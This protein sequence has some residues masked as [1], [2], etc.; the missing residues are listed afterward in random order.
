[1]EPSLRQRKVPRVRKGRVRRMLRA[2]PM[3]LLL[4]AMLQPM[5]QPQQLTALPLQLMLQHRLLMA[6]PPPMEPSL[7]QRKVPRVR[8]GRVR[9]MLRAKPMVLLLVGML[10]PMPQPQQPTALPLQLMLQPQR[11]LMLLSLSQPPPTAPQ[12]LLMALLLQARKL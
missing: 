1:M 9:R 5:P 7:R 12:L 8:K 3:S 10:Q 4:Q 6:L 11:H 2:K